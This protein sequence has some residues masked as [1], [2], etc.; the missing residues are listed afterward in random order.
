M[1]SLNNSHKENEVERM[2]V[3]DVQW[4]KHKL[5]AITRQR[6]RRIQDSSFK[7]RQEK[8]INWRQL[9]QQRSRRN[10]VNHVSKKNGH[11]D[12]R[13]KNQQKTTNKPKPPPIILAKASRW[14]QLRLW[15]TAKSDTCLR[16]I[17]MKIWPTTDQ[18]Y[19]KMQKYFFEIQET[20]YCFALKEH[21]PF[22]AVIKGI[23]YGQFISDIHP[24]GV[25]VFIFW[26]ILFYCIENQIDN[27][28]NCY[29]QLHIQSYLNRYNLI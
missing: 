22:Q 15:K 13:R 18:D 19:R 27:P 4:Y 21:K 2:E 7:K 11:R 14:F 24:F 20:F 1:V 6:Q 28:T 8:E 25:N 12:C 5:R 9:R 16:L 29:R 23:C 3:A 26:N 10:T 17:E